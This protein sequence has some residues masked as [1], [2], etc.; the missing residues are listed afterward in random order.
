MHMVGDIRP[1][2]QVQPTEPPID[3]ACG[4]LRRAMTAAAAEAGV[5]T[6]TL[7]VLAPANDPFR[8][9]IESR[10]RDG[11]WVAATLQA[12]GVGDRKVHGRGL[13]YM[14]I[15]QPKPDG[16]P[17]RNTEDDWDWLM[18]RALKSARWNGYVDFDQ[19]VDQRNAEPVVRVFTEAQPRPYV[20]VGVEVNIPSVE[21]FT[22]YVGAD[23]DSPDGPRDGFPAAQPHKLVLIGEKS[24]LEP[25]LA[26]IARR[27]LADLYLPTGEPSDTMLHR[28]A[29]VGEQDGRPLV[30]LY[31]SDCDPS[32]W[33][34][35]VSVSR[36]LQ[37]LKTLKFPALQFQ[38]HRVA[39]TPDQVREYGLPS[40]PLKDTERRADRWREAMGVQQTEIDAL[41][42]LRPDLLRQIVTD[43]I[44]PFF[45]ASLE[46]RAAEAYTRWQAQAQAA[47]DASLDQDQLARIRSEAARRLGELREQIDA[48][49]AALR[50]DVDMVDLPPLVVPRAATAGPHPAP[51]VSSSWTFADQ[52]RALIASKGYQREVTA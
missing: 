50:V 13:H 32:G 45:D 38:V 28:M 12:L 8:C 15:G 33:Q 3:D 46:R 27:Y 29:R 11:Q 25:V 52:C 5:P 19:I 37:A 40:T 10:H 42:S 2:R 4:P 39:L 47:L 16:T 26:P 23:H 44:A 14:L 9:D 49:N 35:P 17:Y 30:V 18:Q 1:D 34:M 6:N 36:K 41:A 51:L 22:P 43:A 48:I 21:D 20:S 24:S 7:T 31:L